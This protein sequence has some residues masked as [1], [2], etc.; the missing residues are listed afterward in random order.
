RLKGVQDLPDVFDGYREADLVVAGAGERE[1]ELRARGLPNVHFVGQL[2]PEALGRLYDRAI[3]VLVPSR[4]YEAV[5][6]T[7]AE[8]LT[9]G[10]PVTAG[11]IGALTEHME[12]A[13]GGI[14]FDD[15][16]GCRRAMDLLRL[17]PGRRTALGQ[18]GRLAAQGLWSPNRHI[19]A[20]LDLVEGVL[21][22]SPTPP[23]AVG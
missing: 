5:G 10:T 9:R 11:R 6:L 22:R 7:V 20:Y 14:L 4:C 16:E 13:G 21:R 12:Q 23:L 3:A 18:R 19:E 15:L 1:A 2:H 17:D 8:S